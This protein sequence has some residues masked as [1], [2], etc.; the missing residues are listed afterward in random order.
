MLDVR[1]WTFDVGCSMLDVRC[2]MFDVGRSML[3]VRCW[4]FDVGCSMLDV[5]CWMF[6]V[7]RSMLDVRC[8]MFP[9][10]L[11]RSP[12]LAPSEP[13]EHESEG[14]QQTGGTRNKFR[15]PKI[16]AVRDDFGR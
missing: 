2:W 14:S 8:S 13:S 15:A 10:Q 6:D 1:C 11:Q 3:D 7:G 12:F 5:R 4:T 16:V 9:V